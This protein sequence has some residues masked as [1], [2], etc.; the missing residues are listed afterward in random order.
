MGARANLDKW[1]PTH[2]I[3]VLREMKVTLRKDAGGTNSSSI[4][5]TLEGFFYI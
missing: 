5:V 1:V 4:P 2:C 3:L